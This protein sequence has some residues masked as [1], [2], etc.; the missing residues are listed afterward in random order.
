[1]NVPA[2]PKEFRTIAEHLLPEIEQEWSVGD[3]WGQTNRPRNHAVTGAI[4]ITTTG[5]EPP[6]QAASTV[7]CPRICLTF[8]GSGSC[9]DRWAR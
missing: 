1:M 3:A 2:N 5:D 4:L 9:R 7:G 8:A 6:D